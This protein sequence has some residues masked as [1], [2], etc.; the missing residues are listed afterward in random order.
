MLPSH[1]PPA[2][3]PPPPAGHLAALR[4]AWL[5][6]KQLLAS[7]A[8][9]LRQARL[10][11]AL[12]APRVV[13]L[14]ARAQIPMPPDDLAPS[15]LP[16]LS[17]GDATL[18]QA[19]GAGSGLA[20]AAIE[21]QVRRMARARPPGP[22]PLRSL[23]G[24]AHAWGPA[25]HLL[26]ALRRAMHVH[27]LDWQ[28]SLLFGLPGPSALPA[29]AGQASSHLAVRGLSL[30]GAGAGHQDAPQAPAPAGQR[31]QPAHLPAEGQGRP[32]RGRAHHADHPRRQCADGAGA[33][34]WQ[35]LGG[36]S[37][38]GKGLA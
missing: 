29:L 10:P 38:A 22:G 26:A 3:P 7:L 27:C 21:D 11:L 35:V 30:A 28:G 4:R 19:A 36:V 18:Q 13:G 20:I 1:G 17:L 6:F 8:H 12:L 14:A 2:P 24:A 32:A 34:G 23:C 15:Q 9:E 37:C 16:D 33:G 31:R 25:R 5:P